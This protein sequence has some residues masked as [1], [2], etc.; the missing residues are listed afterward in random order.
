[1]KKTFAFIA[2]WMIALTVGYLAVRGDSDSS[3]DPAATTAATPA[4]PTTNPSATV[5]SSAPASSDGQ[6]PTRTEDPAAPAPSADGA[7]DVEPAPAVKSGVEAY[8]PEEL[9][10][11]RV[12]DPDKYTRLTVDPQDRNPV[13]KAKLQRRIDAHPAYQHMPYERDGV[14][15]DFTGAQKGDR[16]ELVVMHRDGRKAAERALDRFLRA[17]GDTRAGYHIRFKGI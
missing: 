10:R 2:C 3:R 17:H 14:K 1:M 12:E 13:L 4:S 8:T 15:V 16:I 11:L 5:P 6:E 9:D 7:L